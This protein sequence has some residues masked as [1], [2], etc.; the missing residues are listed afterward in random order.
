MQAVFLT[1]DLTRRV[2]VSIAMLNKLEDQRSM[3]EGDT[4]WPEKKLFVIVKCLLTWNRSKLQHAS[5][6]S[7]IEIRRQ[8]VD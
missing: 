5:T 8:D 4:S 6:R 1:G 3:V 7:L 2:F